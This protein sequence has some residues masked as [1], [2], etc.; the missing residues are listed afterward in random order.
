MV[1]IEEIKNIKSGKKE[2]RK[3]GIT[4]GIVLG[5]LGGLF[6]WREREWY[7]YFFILSAVFVFSGITA[8]LLLWPVQKVWM[9]LAV[10]LGWVMTRV[11]LIILFYLVVTP[12]GLLA[13][14]LGK[15]FLNLKF[16]RD[17]DSYWIPKERVKFERSDYE[18]QF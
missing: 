17:A 15:D 5:L 12:I 18:R 8:P 13:K 11:I 3:F 10:L 14:L 6:L 7:Y 4:I 16:D 1:I 9:G 2:L